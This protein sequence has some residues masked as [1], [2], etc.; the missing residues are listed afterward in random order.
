MAG[1]VS[2]ETEARRQE[3]QDA[4]AAARARKELRDHQAEQRE[5]QNLPPLPPADAPLPP[6]PPPGAQS[7]F[8]SGETLPP[9]SAGNMATR[10]ALRKLR[11]EQAK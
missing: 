10:A 8:K 2:P 11:A 6:A 3:I 5:R 7:Y 9:G 4:L 1:A